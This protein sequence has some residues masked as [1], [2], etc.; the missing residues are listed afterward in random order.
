MEYDFPYEVL[1]LRET[2]IAGNEIL[3]DILKAKQPIT[4]DTYFNWIT[5]SSEENAFPVILT[6]L[7]KLHNCQFTAKKTSKRGIYLMY[8]TAPS[9][10]EL[11][12]LDYDLIV[13]TKYKGLKGLNERGKMHCEGYLP[14]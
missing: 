2:E 11:I 12:A 3:F 6:A 13:Y 8:I 14:W 7:M 5:M 9:V 1:K 4:D 10:K